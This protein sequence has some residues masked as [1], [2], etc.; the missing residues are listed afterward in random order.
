MVS[1]P[2]TDMIH[3]G[4]GISWIDVHGCGP[5]RTKVLGK[6]KKGHH[7]GTIG[8][9]DGTTERDVLDCLHQSARK[10]A[11]Y[12]ATLPFELWTR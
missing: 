9:I 1:L 2:F 5:A 12:V 8:E 4:R 3:T 7:A 6:K 10:V 11:S